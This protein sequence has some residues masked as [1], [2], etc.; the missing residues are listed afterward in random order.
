MFCSFQRLE[1]K[2]GWVLILLCEPG[3]VLERLIVRDYEIGSL[4]H[5]YGN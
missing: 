2:K 4:L 1:M 5:N 3:I